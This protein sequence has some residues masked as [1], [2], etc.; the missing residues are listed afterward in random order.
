MKLVMPAF[1]LGLLACGSKPA[2]AVGN[3]AGAGGKQRN[4]AAVVFVEAA[5]G[6]MEVGCWD[7]AAGAMT[8]IIPYGDDPD[9]CRDRAAGLVDGKQVVRGSDGERYRLTGRVGDGCDASGETMVA[10]VAREGGGPTGDL[11]IAVW[12]ADVDVRWRAFPPAY[13]TQMPGSAPP[14]A[15]PADV[16]AKIAALGTADV[17]ARGEDANTEPRAIDPV[18]VEV[19]QIVDADV[20]GDGELDRLISATVEGG[21]Y[22]GYLW[23]GA[24]LVRGSDAARTVRLWHSDLEKITFDGS[25][26]LDGDGRL[27]FAYAAEYYEG[28]GVGVARI[29]GDDLI[30]VGG[31]GC[32]A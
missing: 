30:I 27:E 12:P 23:S 22:A 18:E 2:P 25:F 32:G 20:D 21:G 6:I 1:A 24:V 13:D 14:P 4:P 7:P 10:S 19:L 16:R 9:P 15:I 5:E 28:A 17:M 29:E 8:G 31:Y 11:T 3:Q 26:D